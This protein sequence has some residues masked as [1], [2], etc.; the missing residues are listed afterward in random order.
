[1]TIFFI[2]DLNWQIFA[3]VVLQGKRGPQT[4]KQ[5]LYNTLTCKL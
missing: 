5:G 3:C 2:M 4:A 1:M